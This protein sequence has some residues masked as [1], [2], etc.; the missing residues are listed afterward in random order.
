MPL[1]GSVGSET[2]GGRGRERD[3]VAGGLTMGIKGGWRWRG[4]GVKVEV[5]VEMEE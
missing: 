2:G 5:E 1:V 3:F 4:M